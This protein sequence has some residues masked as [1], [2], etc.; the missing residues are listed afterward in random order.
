MFQENKNKK[1]SKK[2]FKKLINYLFIYFFQKILFFIF[3]FFQ[4]KF[5][6][7]LPRRSRRARRLRCG[8]KGIGTQ[9][10]HQPNLIFFKKFLE[11]F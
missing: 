2:N 10:S 8:G 9:Q 1:I 4:K 6:P 3:Y 5:N 7:P 11:T